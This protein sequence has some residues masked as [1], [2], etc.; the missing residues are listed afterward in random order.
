MKIRPC[1]TRKD[2]RRDRQ[3]DTTKLTVIFLNSANAPNKY[4]VLKVHEKFKGP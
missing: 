4:K 3:T 1:S 2:G